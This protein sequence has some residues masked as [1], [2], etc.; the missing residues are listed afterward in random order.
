VAGEAEEAARGAGSSLL[1]D[2]A[3]TAI[4]AIVA[5]AASSAA[6][7]LHTGLIVPPARVIPDYVDTIRYLFER[8]NSHACGRWT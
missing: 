2:A 6:R 3:A 7:V 8:C 5:V 4:R 1:P